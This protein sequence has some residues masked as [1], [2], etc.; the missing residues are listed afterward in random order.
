MNET[1][2]DNMELFTN[3]DDKNIS[4]IEGTPKE[5]IDF[6]AEIH[7]NLR[8]FLMSAKE[9]QAPKMSSIFYNYGANPKDELPFN[10]E[11]R[12]EIGKDVDAV[13]YILESMDA[14]TSA[15]LIKYSE[16]SR[17]SMNPHM[18]MDSK[19]LI[20]IFEKA[21]KYF[22]EGYLRLK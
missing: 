3:I 12:P 18:Q 8:E 16:M 19:Q 17:K 22:K 5:L 1:E 7:E 4:G 13:K 14:L 10:M 9:I 6:K 2:K 21:F 15:A 20:H 11:E